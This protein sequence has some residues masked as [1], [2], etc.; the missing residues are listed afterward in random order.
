MSRL[1]LSLPSA[2]V[3]RGRAQPVPA[4]AAALMARMSEAPAPVRSRAI[5]GLVGSLI[6]SGIWQKLDLLYVLAAHDAQA[7]RLNWVPWTG[8]VTNHVR[9]NAMVGAVAGN[10]GTRPTGWRAPFVSGASGVSTAIV[11]IGTED[12]I[13]YLDWRIF[14]TPSAAGSVFLFPHGDNEIAAAAGQLWSGSAFVRLA[15][16][17]LAGSTWSGGFNGLFMS[18]SDGASI[19]NGPAVAFTPVAGPLSSGRIRNEA[20]TLPANAA[21][22][23]LQIRFGIMSGVPIDFT[24]RIG[25]PQLVQMDVAGDPIRTA[26]AAVSAVQTLNRFDLTAVNSPSFVADQGYAGGTPAYLATGYNPATDGVHYLQNDAHIALWDLTNR[27]ASTA[28]QTG[29]GP[30]GT[31]ITLMA[32]R[33]TGDVIYSRVNDTG[34]TL[35]NARSDGFFL[36]NR[37]SA[38][39]R[40]TYRDGAAIGT[41][42]AASQAVPSVPVPVLCSMLNGAP[43]YPTTDRIAVFSMGAGLTAAEVAA[44]H[45][46][47]RT[48]LQAAGA[49]A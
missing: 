42:A 32:T 3:L 4:Q 39:E 25:W 27:A 10:P 1:G 33:Y 23:N 21:F 6:S 26:G 24:L 20:W 2:A 7:A 12:G 28:T 19:T 37:L 17:S 13:D 11:G 8:S 16:G 31:S 30:S 14:G 35:P 18:M 45:A 34:G 41:L 40:T 46:A 9:N 5:G 44:F 22:V 29:T 48:Y 36:A 15:A 38:A 47:L 43:A 49:V